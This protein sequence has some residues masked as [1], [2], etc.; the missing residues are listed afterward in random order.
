MTTTTFDKVEQALLRVPEVMLVF[1]I[2]K[3]LSTTVGETGADYLAVDGGWGMPN[4]A[5]AMGSI[6]AV[7][8]FLQFGKLKRYVPAN[9]WT[10]VVLMSVIGTLITDILV[11]NAGISLVTLSIVFTV[12]MLA[13]FYLWYRQE[14]TLS[15]HSIDTGKR[16]GWYW[17]VILLAFALGTGVGDLISEHLNAGYG[18]ALMLFAGL[19][20]AVAVAFYGF[21]LNAVT[22]FWF[23]F[24]LTRPLGAS[25]GDFLIQA[26]ANGG[27]GINILAVN[28]GFLAAIAGL[29]SYEALRIKR[30]LA[31]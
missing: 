26:P 27:L 10:L 13:G 3:T 31:N 9:Y 2:I 19:I 20:G 7:L 23:A 11:D 15:I 25:L 17:V 4:T 14:G 21:K 16:E 8:L 22:A 5:V 29:V 24:V 30:A 6:M 28:V 18:V 1:W 12:A